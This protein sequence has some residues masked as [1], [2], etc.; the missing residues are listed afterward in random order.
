MRVGNTSI[1]VYV[2]VYAQR[3][4]R[5]IETVKVTEATL[6]YVATGPDR[7]PR[8][9]PACEPGLMADSPQAA[10]KAGRLRGAAPRGAFAP[11]SSPRPR[12]MMADNIEHVISYWVMFQKFHSPALAG[13]AVLSHWLPFLLFSVYF[14]AL[15]DRYDCR[16]IIQIALVLFMGVSLAWGLLFLTDTIELWHAVVLLTRARHGGRHLGT[17]EPAPR[18]TTSSG[19]EQL[20]SAVR[21]LGDQPLPRTC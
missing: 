13:F 8:A 12:A 7:K 20:Q 4:P 2:E 17:G 11:I 14:G 6:T 18:S 19:R 3:N 1:T 21:L 10:A 9:V 15:A 5:D 16:R